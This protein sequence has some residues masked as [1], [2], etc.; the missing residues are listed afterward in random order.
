LTTLGTCCWRLVS[1]HQCPKCTRIVLLAQALLGL[2]WKQL[3]YCAFCVLNGCV[4]VT[5][6]SH[7][8]QGGSDGVSVPAKPAPWRPRHAT[9]GAS[10][11]SAMMEAGRSTGAKKIAPPPLVLLSSMNRHDGF[12]MLMRFLW[13]A[14]RW[15]TSPS[16]ETSAVN[17]CRRSIRSKGASIH[18]LGTH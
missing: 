13:P 6:G 16:W 4:A 12:W 5:R 3:Q 9:S 1:A 14:N 7:V 11:I 10:S 17:T 15:S 8:A 2:A 18:C